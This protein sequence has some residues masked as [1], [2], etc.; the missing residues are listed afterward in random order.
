MGW[1]YNLQSP[2]PDHHIPRVIAICL[3]FSS[4]AC[5]AVA[6]RF[7]V[8]IWLKKS[9]WV[10]D[11]AALFSAVLG[12]AYAALAVAQTRWGLGLHADYFPT[13]NNVPF[14][15]MQYIG[16]PIYTLALLGFKISL[17]ASY[18][19]IGGFVHSYRM[20]ILA[21]IVACVCNQIVFT[22]VLSFG[23]QPIARQWD[24]SIPGTCINTVA[25]YYGLAGTSLGFDV[26]IIAFPL[27]ILAQ[28]QLKL[29]QKILLGFLFGLG[30]FVTIIQI[31]R[32]FTIKNLKTYTDSQPIIIWSDV[33]ISLGVIISCIP[34]Y[35]PY[36][37]AVAINI[38]SYRRRPT[39]ASG[40]SYVLSSR[41]VK[42]GSRIYDNS[43]P[44]TGMV[45]SGNRMEDND[46]EESIL[47]E[48]ESGEQTHT[49]TKMGIH[50]ATEVRV[51]R[52][53]PEPQ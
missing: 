12:M 33:E 28:L 1:V 35:G 19:R 8:R 6:L 21:A 7:H 11:F 26:I 49:Q 48:R 42:S 47:A 32:I 17:L 53:P 22:I 23:C 36:F 46:S 24:P 10:D 30:F 50:I 5:V 37:R 4:A 2:D 51:E 20:V 3:V 14:S 27:P 41:N 9:V 44:M 15:K 38:S 13:A 18:F 31:I 16:G 43:L 52:G 29:R 34:T 25:S 40:Q 39:Q 45:I